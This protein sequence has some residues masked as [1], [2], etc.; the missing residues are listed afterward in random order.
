MTRDD[1]PVYKLTWRMYLRLTWKRHLLALV[2]AWALLAVV[3]VIL[4]G[5]GVF[6]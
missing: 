1:G 6:G 5:L 4:A 3:L 2:V